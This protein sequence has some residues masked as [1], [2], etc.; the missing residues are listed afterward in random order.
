M[1]GAEANISASDPRYRA[2]TRRSR[3]RT[4]NNAH[5]TT[6][7]SF[8]TAAPIGASALRLSC[9]RAVTRCWVPLSSPTRAG[10]RVLQSVQARTVVQPLQ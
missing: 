7:V 10:D 1:S 9:T 3:T 4:P 5:R 8:E 6:A 2:S